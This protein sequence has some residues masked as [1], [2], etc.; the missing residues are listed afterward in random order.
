MA[1]SRKRCRQNASYSGS[2]SSSSF[3]L[4]GQ[5]QSQ[6]QSQPQH[7]SMSGD[8]AANCCWS[9]KEV[10]IE[11][12]D[13]AVWRAFVSPTTGRV[14]FVHLLT[15][16]KQEVVPP[17]FADNVNYAGPFAEMPVAGRDNSTGMDTEEVGSSSSVTS[18]GQQQQSTQQSQQQSPFNPSVPKSLGVATSPIIGRFPPL[19]APTKLSGVQA[20]NQASYQHSA[21]PPVQQ[22]QL[23]SPVY[24][25]SNRTVFGSSGGGGSS[26]WGSRRCASLGSDPSGS[27]N[28]H[29]SVSINDTDSAVVAID[30]DVAGGG[31]G[32]GV[33]VGIENIMVDDLSGGGGDEDI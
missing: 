32:G 27:S 10:I 23:Q 4:S 6:S 31:A 13:R 24:D 14:Y 7:L 16:L 30:A 28:D 8:F 19:D 26:H 9:N 18:L 15:N 22:Q 21:S 1:E 11:G 2:S 3:V 20:N 5:Q 33:G 29:I 17:G 12:I 25:I